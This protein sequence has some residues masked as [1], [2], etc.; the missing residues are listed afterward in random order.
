[1][2]DKKEAIRYERLC[3]KLV[4][5]KW[6]KSIGEYCTS[7]D[8]SHTTVE[9]SKQIISVRKH[10]P[11][12]FNTNCYWGSVSCLTLFP[13]DF[14]YCA[15]LFLQNN[16]GSRRDAPFE[17]IFSGLNKA[18]RLTYPSPK[19]RVGHKK[20][21]STKIHPK[22]LKEMQTAQKLVG[23][24]GQYLSTMF[25]N[26]LIIHTR[27]SSTLQWSP[28]HPFL[29]VRWRQWKDSYPYWYRRPYDHFFTCRFLWIW[30]PGLRLCIKW[31]I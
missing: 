5:A 20:S 23:T 8:F 31:H 28:R 12:L 22:W 15:S 27:L 7:V 10:A 17:W 19:Y 14:Y 4:K 26:F 11:T 16:L 24:F 6:G 1:M 18:R 30:L 25:N 9:G 29:K 21:P 13:I 3:W 2:I